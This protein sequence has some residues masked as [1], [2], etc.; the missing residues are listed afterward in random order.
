MTV[1]AFLWRSARCCGISMPGV[2][3]GNQRAGSSVHAWEAWAGLLGELTSTLAHT[4]Y[5]CNYLQVPTDVVEK[6]KHW[7][8]PFGFG[9]F[10]G[11]TQA[12]S[13]PHRAR[14]PQRRSSTT[15]RESRRNCQQKLQGKPAGQSRST[16]PLMY[17]QN[18]SILRIRPSTA[19][20]PSPAQGPGRDRAPGLVS[21]SHTHAGLFTY[22]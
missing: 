19:P 3:A 2:E 6:S 16:V 18:T 1:C 12:N 13:K 7:R 11:I 17:V 10:P 22:H 20:A 8:Q 5:V 15:G 21:M 4:V 14:L 9:P